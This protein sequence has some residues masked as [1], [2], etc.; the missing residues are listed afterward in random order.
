MITTEFILMAAIIVFLLMVIGMIL[1]MNEFEKI[2]EEPS[3]RKG[4]GSVVRKEHRKA[5]HTSHS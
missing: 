1:T 4:E 2:T 5:A 3:Q